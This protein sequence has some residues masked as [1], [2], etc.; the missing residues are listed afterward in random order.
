MHKTH[1]SNFEAEGALS[2]FTPSGAST[3]ALPPKCSS[4]MTRAPGT[5]WTG[6][7]TVF[8]FFSSATWT[9]S[10]KSIVYRN[11]PNVTSFL[12]VFSIPSATHRMQTVLQ[13]KVSLS[14]LGI[15]L[16]PLVFQG[17]QKCFM[18][19]SAQISPSEG[20]LCLLG[21]SQGVLDC[22]LEWL[23]TCFCSD[24]LSLIFLLLSLPRCA[25]LAT[26]LILSERQLWGLKE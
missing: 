6:L 2:G 22:Y 1:T 11:F 7:Y 25:I 4:V 21:E 5:T 20:I 3:S 15:I 16:H 17:E 24:C 18:H 23:L 26:E 14:S 10:D 19:S 13:R 9:P 12:S 8:L